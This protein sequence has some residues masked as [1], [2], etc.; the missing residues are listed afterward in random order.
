M[1]GNR[2]PCEYT[3]IVGEFAF[4]TQATALWSN[5]TRAISDRPPS[6]LYIT[7]VDRRL[8]LI[9][10]TESENKSAVHIK[11]LALSNV[12]KIGE[13]AAAHSYYAYYVTSALLV[14]ILL[15]VHGASAENSGSKTSF[16]PPL[17]V[18]L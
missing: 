5:P 7:R 9:R 11:C 1:H 17:E 14:Q 16:K 18:E 3:R 15:I 4:Y 13:H 6:L 8:L 12:N 2:P 10:N